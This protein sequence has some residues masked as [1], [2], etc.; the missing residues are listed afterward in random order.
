MTTTDATGIYRQTTDASGYVVPPMTDIVESIDGDVIEPP[1]TVEQRLE[2]HCESASRDFTNGDYFHLLAR[3]ALAEITRL[4][5]LV[6]EMGKACGPLVEAC[7][8]EMHGDV[9]ADEPDDEPVALM[10][11][12]KGGITGGKITFGM[13]R[14][15]RATLAKAKEQ[16]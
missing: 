10:S 14:R 16:S 13:I 2:F 7:Y 1:L 6:E 3:D 5:A 12:G 9:C 15:A 4:R 11:D 8:E